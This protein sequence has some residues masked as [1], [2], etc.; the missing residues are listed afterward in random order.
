V[1]GPGGKPAREQLLH[2][3]SRLAGR[4]VV[5][6]VVGEVDV[7]TAGRL[8]EAISV[9]FA[10]PA[11][12]LVVV[13]LTEVTFL[14]SSGLTAL[15]TATRE[16][17]DRREPLRVVVDH[18]RPVIRPIQISGLDDVLALYHSLE[19]ALAQPP[20]GSGGSGSSGST[21]DRPH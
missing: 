10:E 5:L 12:E 4:A 18:N 6:A 15:V 16:A 7:H 14:G 21:T 2:I 17:R 1:P 13:D 9:G 20:A 8:G 11:A 19:D 3:T